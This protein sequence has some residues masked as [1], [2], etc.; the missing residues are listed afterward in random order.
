M[1]LR[2]NGCACAT[3][4]CFSTHAFVDPSRVEQ[5]FPLLC[6]MYNAEVRSVHT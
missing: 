3:V 2:N 1:I 5:F 6:L 4:D